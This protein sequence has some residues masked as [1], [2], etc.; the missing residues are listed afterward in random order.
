MRNCLSNND[1]GED[2]NRVRFVVQASSPAGLGAGQRPAPQ[3]ENVQLICIQLLTA[4]MTEQFTRSCSRAFTVGK[5]HLTI[6]DNSM[7]PL[8][9]LDA[10]PLATREVMS[11]FT[12]P[13]WLD[14]ESVQVVYHHVRSRAFAQHSAITEA[15]GMG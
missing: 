11:N 6:D 2:Q 9:S 5:G 14:I 8:G 4:P 12:N 13:V 15:C 1:A 3:Y 10:T 7:I